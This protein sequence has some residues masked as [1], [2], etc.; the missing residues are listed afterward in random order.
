M[1]APIIWIFFPALI[2]VLMFILKDK[3][4][5]NYLFIGISA[6]LAA[7]ALVIKIDQVGER[8]FFSLWIASVQNVLGR[9][10]ILQESNK[11]LIFIIYFFNA[12]W[13][14]ASVLL[15]KDSR[16]IPVGLMYTAFLLAAVSVEPFLYSALIIEIAVILSIPLLVNPKVE[17]KRGIARFL[18]YQTLALPFIL[19]AGWFLAGGE[20]SPVNPDQLVQEALLLGLG[21]MFWLAVFPFH[22]WVPMVFDESNSIDTGY[23]FL[24]LQIVFF[25]LILKFINGFAW[26]RTYSVFFQALRLLGII[27]AVFGSLGL[28]F[29]KSIRKIVGYE[30]LRSIGI[31]LITVGLVNSAGINLF[32]YMIGA[33]LISF[34]L[35]S[36]A[37]SSFELPDQQVSVIELNGFAKEK[38]AAI[39]AFLFP[40]LSLSGMPLTL[41]FSP[42]QT[43]YQNL[44]DGFPFML[45]L[46]II[47]NIL[48]TITVFRYIREILRGEYKINQIFASLRNDIFLVLVLILVVLQGLVP[49]IILMRF[50]KLV[51]GFEFLIK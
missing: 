32:S 26:L 36:W 29:E 46:M 18:I 13:G 28:F 9:S 48:V 14:L 4:V 7:A 16:F 2:S 10:L 34:S 3:R 50:E 17:S 22:S 41:G 19:L 33:R 44:A 42:L 24:L 38:P 6:L 25:V 37:V 49:R 40:F 31:L 35:L 15:K 39:A 51:E 1:N 12:V 11:F 20:I 23:I 5:K 21:F 45:V 8:S 43:M 47:C 27:M 30:F